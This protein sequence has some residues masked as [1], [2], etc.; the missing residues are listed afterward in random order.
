VNLDLQRGQH[1]CT[2]KGNTYC[3]RCKHAE[4]ILALIKSGK[5]DVPPAKPQPELM[6]LEDL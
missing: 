6:P 5:I 2:C 4:A 1:S 3:G